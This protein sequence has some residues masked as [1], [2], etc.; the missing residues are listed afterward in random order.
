MARSDRKPV[1]D[2]EGKIVVCDPIRVI[3][4]GENRQL[5]LTFPILVSVS[6]VVTLVFVYFVASMLQARV[7]DSD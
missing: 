6:V 5:L 2:C 7:R 3:N 4:G 1:I